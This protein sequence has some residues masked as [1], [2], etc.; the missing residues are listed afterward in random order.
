MGSNYNKF[1][2]NTLVKGALKFDN[3]D[4][5]AYFYNIEIYHGYYWHLSDNSNFK[6]S[7]DISSRDM[8]SFTTQ[9]L[10]NDGSFMMTS[11]LEY[12]DDYYNI[13]PQT[14]KRD[15][16]RKFFVLLDASDI[17]P[18]NLQQVSR[19]F[20]NEVSLYKK[21]AIKLKILGVYKRNY[22]KQLDRKFHNILPQSKEKLQVL[23]EYAHHLNLP[24]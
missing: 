2:L 7:E 19:G 5:F 12:W 9:K 13:N 14:E 10:K 15:I 17:D 1:P 16:K 20:G 22:A 4:D 24:G 18:I 21:D 3:F 23:W 6:Y 8:S 11:H